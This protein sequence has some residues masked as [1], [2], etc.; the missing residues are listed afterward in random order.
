MVRMLLVTTYYVLTYHT[1][2]VLCTPY[3]LRTCMVLLL[4][5]S[6][7]RYTNHSSLSAHL[8]GVTTENTT[9][10]E[11]T[12]ITSGCQDIRNQ[13]LGSIS[14][15]QWQAANKLSNFFGYGTGYLETDG[16]RVLVSGTYEVGDN[17]N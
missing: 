1:M 16:S 10:C 9:T 6:S 8:S 4:L 12:N 2:Y 11:P 7:G 13:Q 3:V 14:G 17:D 15:S 5:C